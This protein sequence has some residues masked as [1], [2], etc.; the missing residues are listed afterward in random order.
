MS[1]SNV[2]LI[3]VDNFYQDPDAVREFALKQEFKVRGNYPGQ[4]T[5]SFLNDGLK[6]SIQAILKPH[7]GNVTYWGGGEVNYTGAFQY[8]TASD[9]SWI[10]SDGTTKW[11]GVLYLTPDAPITAGTGL[12]RHKETGLRGWNYGEHTEEETRACAANRE[13]QDYTK[14][15]MTD[16]VGNIYN[17]L[18]LYRGDM[19]HVSLDY[20]GTDKYDGRLF[21][22]FF[23]DTE[24]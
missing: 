7:A 24:K 16:M 11:A 8:V 22:T 13:T 6:E 5:V 2:N 4:R 12:F 19:Y 18:V 14:W 1:R 21:Q 3:V 10:H 20:F 15:E 9:R 23:I 17:R